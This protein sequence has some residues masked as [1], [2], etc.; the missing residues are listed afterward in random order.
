MT[1]EDKWITIEQFTNEYPWPTAS[2]MRAYIVRAE[3]KGLSA[4]FMRVGARVLVKPLRFFELLSENDPSKLRL[5]E[6]RK[7]QRNSLMKRAF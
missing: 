7:R 5:K 3:E 2:G 6:K 4:A 1:I